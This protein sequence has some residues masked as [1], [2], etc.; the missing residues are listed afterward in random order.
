MCMGSTSAVMA[1]A[2][3]VSHRLPLARRLRM[4]GGRCAARQ[5]E[6]N[7]RTCWARGHT[8]NRSWDAFRAAHVKMM[9]RR[10][11]ASFFLS[12]GLHECAA[13]RWRGRPTGEAL[14]RSSVSVPV[15]RGYV[16]LSARRGGEIQGRGRAM[17]QIAPATTSTIQLKLPARPARPPARHASSP[18]QLLP[19]VYSAINHPYSRLLALGAPSRSTGRTAATPLL[20][21]APSRSIE[22]AGNST[23]SSLPPPRRLPLL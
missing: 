22:A 20:G 15:L 12:R 21:T 1:T 18:A 4:Y 7:W 11:E 13:T 23:P 8:F 19:Y 17:L 10:V 6:L 3:T 5:R 14:C 9:A 16:M 2:T